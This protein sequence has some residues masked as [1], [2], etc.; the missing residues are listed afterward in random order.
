MGSARAFMWL[1]TLCAAIGCKKD[2]P[3]SSTNTEPQG[4]F[5]NEPAGVPPKALDA[6]HVQLVVRTAED[7]NKVKALLT[8]FSDKGEVTEFKNDDASVTKTFPMPR[9]VF[10]YRAPKLLDPEIAA[11]AVTATARGNFVLWYPS[12]QIRTRLSHG[13]A[14]VWR[15]LTRMRDALSQQKLGGTP[16]FYLGAVAHVDLPLLGG[17]TPRGFSAIVSK[18]NS[19]LPD[20]LFTSP[21]GTKVAYLVPS[22]TNILDGG[23]SDPVESLMPIIRQGGKAWL[24]IALPLAQKRRSEQ[25]P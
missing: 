4:S 15:G 1:L 17:K 7:P 13:V 24:L 22:K 9:F 21:D 19:G 10:T 12:Q 25:L 2:S 23:L 6:T 3:H 8:Q 14:N 5:L 11:K 18:T 20:P 16:V